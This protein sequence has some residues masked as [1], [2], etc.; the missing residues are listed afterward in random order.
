MKILD[1]FQERGILA[2]TLNVVENINEFLLSL[3]PGDEKEYTRFDSVCKSA[4][5]SGV[6]NVKL[7]I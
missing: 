5:N 3:V 7:W 6:Q 2:P 4:E 1:S